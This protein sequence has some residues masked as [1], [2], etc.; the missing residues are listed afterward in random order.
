M[1][2]GTV[3]DRWTII[4]S[5]SIM[6]GAVWYEKI[7]SLCKTVSIIEALILLACANLFSGFYLSPD[8]DCVQQKCRSWWRWRK[9]KL[10]WWWSLYGKLI[11]HHRHW[12]SH[13]V[14]IGSIL[15][16]LWLCMPLIIGTMALY[17]FGM[18]PWGSKLEIFERAAIIFV[19][20][21]L[22]AL[23]HYWLDNRLIIP[24]PKFI[25]SSD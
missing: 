25:S 3:H 11:P 2:Q 21:E 23:V 4:T 1:A 17:H 7:P 8:L 15:R 10:G 13:G 12:L 5:V 6:L 19:G 24:C 20:I 16:V 22:G 9:L 18:I 14:L